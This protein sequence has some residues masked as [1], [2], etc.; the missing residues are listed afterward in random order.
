MWHYL[1]PEPCLSLGF[2]LNLLV[3]CGGLK[4]L[5]FVRH[6]DKGAHVSISDLTF[7]SD[8][9]FKNVFFLISLWWDSLPLSFVA[10]ASIF[11][12]NYFIYLRKVV[13]SL[14]FSIRGPLRKYA[15]E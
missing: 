14:H 11:G 3:S 4:Y 15:E 5:C 10:P 13:V 8:L 2:D 12:L 1:I 9:L 7:P 6:L